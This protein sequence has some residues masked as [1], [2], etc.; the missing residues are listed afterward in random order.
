MSTLRLRRGSALLFAL[1]VL[2][3][4]AITG[5]G[6]AAATLH[7][8]R[9]TRLQRD[10]STAF[11]IAESGAERALLWLRQQASP[12]GGTTAFDLFGGA[13]TLGSGTYQVRIDPDDANPA[14]ELKRFTIRSTGIAASRREVV[15][16]YVQ[17]ANFGRYAYFTDYERSSVTNGAIYFKAGEIIDGPAHSNN[18]EGSDFNINYVGSTGSIFK[19]RLTAVSD[20][21]NY[22]PSSPSSE[23]EYEQIY[24]DGSRGF[25]LGVNRIELPAN[26][27]RQKIAA[28]GQ[29]GGFPSSM[30]VYLPA[31]GGIYVV[32]DSTMTLSVTPEGWQRIAIVQGSS[33]T[34]V[35]LK[36]DANQTVIQKGSNTNTTSGLPNG[37]IYSTGHITSLKGKLADSAMSGSQ[38][39]HRGAFTV[40]TD[41]VNGKNVTLTDNLTYETTPDMSRPWDDPL[42][43]RAAALGIVARN[44]RIADNAPSNLTL[45]AVALAGGRNTSDGSFYVNNYASKSTGTLNLLG[46]LIQKK[47]GPV[48]T[49]NG[50]TGAQV[51]G[52]A[53][54]YRYDR[55]MAINPP[56][57]FPTTGT[58]ERLSWMR[59]QAGSSLSP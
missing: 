34:T 26:T 23:E 11:N 12:P 28:W 1:F 7:N 35:T 44:I 27:D 37:V 36:Y 39:T 33:T 15:E 52:Y 16:L 13:V 30:G 48:G 38:V 54:H 50:S 41:V 22:V 45:H 9:L 10:A 8:L 6:L 43:L 5:M 42:N 58:Y 55:R 17:Q 4:M 14:T 18:S 49:F 32:G 57:F 47:R 31:A 59:T 25:R 20:N 53:K 40:A 2:M 46:G 3:V 51:S 21:I 29:S 56:P 24:R 19:D